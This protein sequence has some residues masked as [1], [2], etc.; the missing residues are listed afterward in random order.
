M[1]FLPSHFPPPDDK[2]DPA[3]RP[4]W[5]IVAP[6]E[7]PPIFARRSE[8][9]ESD[10]GIHASMNFEWTIY[11]GLAVLALGL[12]ACSSYVNRTGFVVGVGNSAQTTWNE[13]RSDKYKIH[14]QYPPETKMEVQSLSDRVQDAIFLSNDKLGFHV[15][16]IPPETTDLPLYH[17]PPGADVVAWVQ[18]HNLKFDQQDTSHIISGVRAYHG[19]NSGRGMGLDSD[20]FYL[21]RK[22]GLYTIELSGQS[23]DNAAAYNR[24]L[25]SIEFQ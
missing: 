9:T 15:E 14:F 17:P 10:I 4:G 21:I 12:T 23:L 8:A 7:P 20:D 6:S 3:S 25:T 13:Y 24:F 22:D 11:I 2:H 19:S 16:I 1:N 18:Q 5:E